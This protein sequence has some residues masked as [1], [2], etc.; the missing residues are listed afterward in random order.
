ML[1]T[2]KLLLVPS[3]VAAVTLASRRWGMRVGGVLAGLPL[4][5]GPTLAFYAIE[6]GHAFAASAA[7]AAIVGLVAN[8]AFCVAYARSA[9]HIVWP[10]SVA[11]GIG[12][13]AISAIGLTVLPE[14]GGVGET[15]LAVTALAAGRQLIP[16][17]AVTHAAGA[18][19]RWDLPLRML[20]A[21]G[22]VLLFTTLAAALGPRVSGVMSVFPLVTLILAVFAHSQHG[23]DL[24]ALLLRGLL[25]GLYGFVVFCLVLSAMLG[26][27]QAHLL[28][29]LGAALVAQVALQA[30]MLWRM[31]GRRAAHPVAAM[32]SPRSDR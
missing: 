16:V 29:A 26:P 6:Q 17:S 24:V 30:F 1:L 3:L 10:M 11:V 31:A 4:V 18:A 25:K 9:R 14:A 5:A 28:P 15:L 8:T 20:S 19:P 27:L 2:L 21:A 13:F 32:S 22:A 7:R 23:P 12:A